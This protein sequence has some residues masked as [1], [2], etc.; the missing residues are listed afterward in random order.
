MRKTSD[1]EFALYELRAEGGDALGSDGV[2][3]GLVL[4]HL[5]LQGDEADGRTLLLLQAK[6]LKDA[7]VVLD[8]AVDEYE[9][10]LERREE[11]RHRF[12]NAF[13]PTP[14]GAFRAHLPGS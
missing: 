1:L 14:P 11:Q 13:P 6:E 8:V 4:G 7:L 10:D 12:N 5:V 3:L 2:T 9:E